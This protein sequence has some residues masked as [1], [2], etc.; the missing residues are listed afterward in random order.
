MGGEGRAA[1]DPSA[2]RS[3]PAAG[4]RCAQP[5]LA[6]SQLPA[7]PPACSTQQLYSKAKQGVTALQRGR[8][9][10]TNRSMFFLHSR[11]SSR[12]L[13]CHPRWNVPPN[14]SL[15]RCVLLPALPLIVCSDCAFPTL[16]IMARNHPWLRAGSVSPPAQ[17]ASAD[18]G[19]AAIE[20]S[21]R[22]EVGAA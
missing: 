13:L 21:W 5:G 14:S 12:P 1:L 9:T 7:V 16:Q 4:Q 22:G 20:G 3:P 17:C 8:K 2:G 11:P 15:A 19:K 6:V 10:K 18:L